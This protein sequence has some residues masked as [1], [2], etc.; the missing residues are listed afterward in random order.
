MKREELN[1]L[2]ADAAAH[3]GGTFVLNLACDDPIGLLNQALA[4]EK[5][6]ALRAAA[7]AAAAQMQAEKTV[8]L[9]PEGLDFAL[10]GAE[11]VRCARSLVLRETPAVLHMLDKGELRACPDERSY[12]SEGLEGKPVVVADAET[13]LAQEGVKYLTVVTRDK[14]AL[15]EAPLGTSVRAVLDAQGVAKSDK[16][17]LLG[18]LTGRMVPAATDAA[19]ADDPDFSLLRPY[20]NDECMADA[21]ASLMAAVREESCQK[22]VLGREGSWHLCAIFSDVTAGKATRESLP[23]I[24]DIGPLIQAGAFCSMGRGMAKLAVSIVSVC[25]AELDMHIVR[26]QCPAGVCSAFN[27]KVY[28]IDPKKCTACGDCVDECDEMAIEGKKNFIHMIDRAMCTG[29]GKCVSSCEEEA[30]VVYDG[31]M[32]LPDKLTRVGR[33][34]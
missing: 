18:G 30:I 20:A 1:C 34:K 28:C 24:E 27:R 4:A 8:L 3:G 19:I 21:A 25:R 23:M 16:P 12:P 31:S 9:L 2:L 29:C 15:V 7:A 10:E 22:C 26:K 14:R 11:T 17:I 5:A 6:E 32:K 13:L 33:F